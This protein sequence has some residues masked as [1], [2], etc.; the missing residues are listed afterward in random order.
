M[1]KFR[2]YG[3]L[4]SCCFFLGFL[5]VSASVFSF[6]LLGLKTRWLAK[7][8]SGSIHPMN[9]RNSILGTRPQ[10]LGAGSAVLLGEKGLWVIICSDDML[11]YMFFY[12]VHTMIYLCATMDLRRVPLVC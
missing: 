1:I 7:S 4:A 9:Q 8:I 5:C 10:D 2:E 3:I 6:V 12:M 11:F